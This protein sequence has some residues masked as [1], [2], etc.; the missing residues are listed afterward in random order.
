MVSFATQAAAPALV[1]GLG[2][3]KLK[4]HSV[5]GSLAWLFVRLRA[6]SLVL[7]TAARWAW[8]ARGL[9]PEAL[10]QAKAEVTR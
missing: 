3:L 5:T 2:V 6:L 10:H 7:R 9:W 4:G 1:V 8:E